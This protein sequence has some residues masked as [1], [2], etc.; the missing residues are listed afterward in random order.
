MSFKDKLL[1]PKIAAALGCLLVFACGFELL[2]VNSRFGLSLRF[3]SYDWLYDLPFVK[4]RSPDTEAIAMIYLDEASYIDLNQPFNQPW[5]RAIH[6]RLLDKLTADGAQAVIFDVVFSDPGPN[7]ASDKLLADAMRRNGHVILAADYSENQS[8]ATEQSRS[9]EMTLVTP[10]APFAEASAGWGIAQLQPDED[11]LVREHNHGPRDKPFTSMTWAAARLL[12]LPA[13]ASNQD[14]FRER[15]INYYGGP[16]NFPSMSY[17]LAF[18]KPAGFFKNKIVFV[19]GRPQTGMLRERKD[20]FRSPYTTWYSDPVFIPAVDVHATILLNLIGQDWL[21]RLPP[22]A[23]WLAISCGALIFGAWLMRFQPSAAVGVTALGAIGFTVMAMLLFGFTR[24][25]FPWM[26]IV[27]AQAPLGLLFT[28]SY[29]SLEWYVMR[30]KLESQREQAWQRIHEQ[31]AL[32]DKAQDAIMVHDLNWRSTYWNPSAERLCGWTANEAA[33]ENVGQLLYKTDAEKFSAARAAVL[34]NGEWMGQLRQTTKSGKEIIIESRWTLVRDAQGRPGS[35]L[36]INTDITERSKLEAQLLRTQRLEGIGTLASGIAH[37]LNNVLTPILLGVEILSATEQKESRKKTLLSIGSS[38]QRGAD[39]VKQILSFSR[40][41]KGEKVS[42]QLKHVIRDLEKILHETFPR[43]LEIKV[44]LGP[45]LQPIL[46]DVTQ[47]HQ[48]LLNLCVNARD[49][50]ADQGSI[51]IKAENIVLTSAE[52][53]QFPGAAPGIFVRLQVQDTGSGIPQEIID[54]IFEPFFTTKEVGK[55]TGLGLSTVAN[56]VK[57]HNGFLDVASVVGQ[58]TTFTILFP[59]SES[60]TATPHMVE[61]QTLTAT[62]SGKTVL[63]VDD[64]PLIRNLLHEVLADHGYRI[65]LAE[66]GARAVNLFQQHLA[67]INVVMVDMMMPVLDG[68]SAIAQMQQLR[69][70]THFV[71]MSGMLQPAK[72]S[73]AAPDAQIELLHKPFNG[74]KILEA[75]TRADALG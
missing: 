58:G 43:S 24:M 51:H 5:D 35:V 49:A 57:Q 3:A 20:Q 32:L 2:N 69:P 33:N 16:D 21:Q 65:V 26:I 36:V 29:K 60:A 7:P 8:S 11:F 41:H 47:L 59:A 54:R 28:I 34:K 48:V 70:G 12:R 17:K 14:R 71:A 62:G 72:L 25:W 9:K 18:D 53:K 66:N 39:M 45:N 73:A 46:G 68:Y 40:G 4:L 63:V 56:I 52:A 31:A 23:E 10:Y 44:E 42:L 50:M 30:R 55:G 1:N 64:E 13:A 75:L 74:Q 27:A 61:S 38:A 6:A 22:A 15:W 19:G 67:E 37:D